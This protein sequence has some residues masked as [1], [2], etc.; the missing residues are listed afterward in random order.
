MTGCLTRFQHD[1]IVNSTQAFLTPRYP[2][3]GKPIPAPVAVF[4]SG[5]KRTACRCLK[6]PLVIALPC[7]NVRPNNTL[8]YG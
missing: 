7:S 5:G 8:S 3:H 4:G 1:A 6:R 2:S